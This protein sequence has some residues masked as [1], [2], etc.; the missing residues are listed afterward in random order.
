MIHHPR[1]LAYTIARAKSYSINITFARGGYEYG[2]LLPNN[3]NIS[4]TIEDM[5]VWYKRLPG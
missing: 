2:G 1:K 4:G 3:T 5:N